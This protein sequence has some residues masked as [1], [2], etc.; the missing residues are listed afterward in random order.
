MRIVRLML[1]MLLALSLT[2]PAFA[3][4]PEPPKAAGEPLPPATPEEERKFSQWLDGAVTSV[5]TWA[6]DSGEL[7][8][9]AQAVRT[10]MPDTVAIRVGASVEHQDE[11]VAQEG[12]N[13][14][15]NDVTAAIKALGV[16]DDQIVTSGYSVTRRHSASRVSTLV[17]SYVA[18][19]TLKITL[20]DFD[21]IGQVLDTAVEHGANDIRDLS[22]SYSDEGSVYREALQDAILAARGKAEAM[23]SAAGVQLYS[24]LRLTESG[25]YSP[26]YTNSYAPMMDS[27]S[28]DSGGGS[29]Q[30]M[31]GDIE[32]SASV[33]MV[34]KIK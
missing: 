7:E 31:A 11:K 29:T 32:V 15:I 8:V 16:A 26:M 10:V 5:E 30:I 13:T 17:A 3:A 9:H 1:C 23:A 19:T 27:A 28:S 25:G 4:A 14:I 12:V 2:L 21:L 18:S 20:T 6:Q 24:L 34:Y 33:S 22:F